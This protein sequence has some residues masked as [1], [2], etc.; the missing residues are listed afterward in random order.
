MP[1]GL[2]LVA[3]HIAA[4]A[5]I[6]DQALHDFVFAALNGWVFVHVCHQRFL[7]PGLGLRFA[8]A[9]AAV[10]AFTG[11]PSTIHVF[12]GLALR[13]ALARGMSISRFAVT[14]LIAWPGGF[15]PI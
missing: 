2:R 13:F 6:L 14:A 15:F 4:P 10:L 11:L 1:V 8:L 3:R 12:K 5:G 9:S 7:S